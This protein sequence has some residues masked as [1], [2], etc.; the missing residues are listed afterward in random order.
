MFVSFYTYNAAGEQ[1]WLVA[2][3]TS[4]DGTTANVTVY[5]P[6]GGMW[7]DAFDP[8]DVN[9]GN[10]WGTGTFTFPTCTA[11]SFS[12]MPNATMMALGFTNL[13]YDLV[14]ALDSG[15]ACPTFVNNEMAAATR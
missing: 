11:G 14:R 1:T 6:E 13:S 15:I 10:V 8:A 9:L 5:M 7:G 3:L 4:Q 12:L 2:Q